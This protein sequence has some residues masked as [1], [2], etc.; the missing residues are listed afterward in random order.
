ML[1]HV[2]FKILIMAV[3]F[4]NCILIGFWTNPAVVTEHEAILSAC[5]HIVFAVFLVEM[6]LKF[7][8][9]FKTFCKN[10]WNLLDFAIGVVLIAGP[11][12]SSDFAGRVKV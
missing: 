3:A 11:R 12:T 1:N 7:C 8:A 4:G 9:D 6:V 5:D 2:I 10:A